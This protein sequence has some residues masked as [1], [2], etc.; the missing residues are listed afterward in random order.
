MKY[1]VGGGIAGLTAA[2]FIAKKGKKVLLCEKENHVG[3]LIGSFRYKGFTFDAG[4]RSIENSG[5]VLPMLKSLGIDI[6][7]S[8]SVV[9]L[10]IEK[11][12]IK[13]KDKSSFCFYL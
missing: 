4:I 12:I 2:S 10:G 3:G 6:D 1:V 8:R 11:D 5:I 13:V 7:F 9:S